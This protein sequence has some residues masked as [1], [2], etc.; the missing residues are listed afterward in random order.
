VLTKNKLQKIKLKN[1]PRLLFH[2]LVFK[3]EVFTLSKILPVMGI[4]CGT[5]YCIC[6]CK[7]LS[8]RPTKIIALVRRGRR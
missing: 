2:M 6:A 4:H 8:D 7:Y 3:S 1:F 5:R